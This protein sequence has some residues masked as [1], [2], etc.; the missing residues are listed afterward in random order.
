MKHILTVKLSNQGKS[1]FGPGPARL[2]SLVEQGY[3]LNQAAE[4]MGMAYSKAW[5]IIRTAEEGFGFPLMTR[6]RGGAGGGGS[7]LT[8]EA[9]DVLRRYQAFRGEL[10]SCADELFQRYFG[11]PER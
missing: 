5:R 4:E 3:S 10:G 7:T 8:P 1:F 9:K 6:K 11:G 2:L